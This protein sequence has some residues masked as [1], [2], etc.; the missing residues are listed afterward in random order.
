MEKL[1]V[2]RDRTDLCMS[3]GVGNQIYVCPPLE[4]PTIEELKKFTKPQ[5]KSWSLAASQRALAARNNPLY[6]GFDISENFTRFK[7]PPRNQWKKYFEPLSAERYFKAIDL[8]DRYLLDNKHNEIAFFGGNRTGKTYF[9][10]K[11]LLAVAMENP[12][13]KIAIFSQQYKTSREVQQSKVYNLMPEEYKN[14]EAGTCSFNWNPA[15]GFYLGRVSFDNGSTI[16]FNTYEQKK[17]AFEGTQYDVIW[18]DESISVQL[19]NT[20]K[21]RVAD[22]TH[23]QLIVSYTPIDGY[24]KTT[25]SIMNGSTIIESEFVKEIDTHCPRLAMTRAGNPA[26]YSHV[27]DNPFVNVKKVYTSINSYQSKEERLCRYAGYIAKTS[28]LE[29]PAFDFK[30]HVVEDNPSKKYRDTCSIHISGNINRSWYLLL[31]QIDEKGNVHAADESPSGRWAELNS[32]GIWQAG[33]GQRKHDSDSIKQRGKDVLAFANDCRFFTID[34]SLLKLEKIDEKESF[35]G[36]R[37]EIENSL[38][39]PIQV[40]P[41]TEDED[42]LKI[43]NSLLAGGRLTVSKKCKNLIA[44]FE[45]L[46]DDKE[47]EHRKPIE[48]LAIGA[49]MTPHTARVRKKKWYSRWTNRW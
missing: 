9:L 8:F 15:S 2:D 21:M 4:Y 40:A 36:F 33:E 19:Y 45:G 47:N 43:V 29:F 25:N 35:Y 17:D 18:A 38:K 46:N 1:I 42:R 22:T 10:C 24:N 31:L 20:L 3:K 28:F 6:Q 32:E 39:A 49:A 11:R 37:R 48:A 27:G 12:D 34:Q 14:Q 41:K 13:M 5:L 7:S 16:T 23:G 44:A 26:I 30:K